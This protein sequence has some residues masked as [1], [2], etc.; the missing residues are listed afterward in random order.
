MSRK[1]F[2]VITRFSALKIRREKNYRN[3]KHEQPLHSTSGSQTG[4]QLTKTFMFNV[5]FHA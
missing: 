4:F 3:I 5:D 1:M 2:R